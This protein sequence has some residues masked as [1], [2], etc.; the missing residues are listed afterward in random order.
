MKFVPVSRNKHIA[1]YTAAC[2][3]EAEP[4]VRPQLVVAAVAKFLSTCEKTREIATF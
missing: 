3:C 4:I 2:V 1:N